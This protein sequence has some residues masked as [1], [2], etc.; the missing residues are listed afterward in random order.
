MKLHNHGDKITITC[1]MMEALLIKEC[2]LS[3]LQKTWEE[4][5]SDTMDITTV[6]LSEKLS[7]IHNELK[8]LRG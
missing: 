6:V 5:G 8:N 3:V 1:S 2:V 4:R 7:V